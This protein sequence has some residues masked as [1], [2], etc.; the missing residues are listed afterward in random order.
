[1]GHLAAKGQPRGTKAEPRPS[2]VRLQ[3]R[4]RH[5][6]HSLRSVSVMTGGFLLAISATV[7]LAKL[8]GRESYGG[9]VFVD[10]EQIPTSL[11]KKI[12]AVVI[13]GGGRPI[14]L[15]EPPKYVQQRCD[16]AASVVRKNEALNSHKRREGHEQLPVLCLSAGTAHLPQLLAPDGLPIWESTSTA[17]YLI[18][19]YSLQNI[20]AETTSFDTI[21]NAFFART[22][23][24]DINGWRRL[25][26]VTSE[27][28]RRVFLSRFFRRQQR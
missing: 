5:P 4:E 6:V 18:K 7:L 26:V 16:D 8:N 15:E 3:K 9:K 25:L 2:M 11:I 20:Y 28:R 10:P 1:M 23:F 27:V 21:G 12:D 14:S 17:A 19:N 24:S 13:L 22:S